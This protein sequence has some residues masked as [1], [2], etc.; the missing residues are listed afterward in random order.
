MLKRHV[1]RRTIDHLRKPFVQRLIMLVV[2][3]LLAMCLGYAT[4]AIV[5]PRAW[6]EVAMSQVS[7]Q[8]SGLMLGAARMQAFTL[9]TCVGGPVR[10]HLTGGQ[11]AARRRS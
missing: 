6:H 8:P 11:H 10:A 3:M 2:S 4:M 5:R 9:S 1:V 7:S